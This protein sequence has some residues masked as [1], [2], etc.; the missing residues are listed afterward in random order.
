MGRWPAR[1]YS[2]TSKQ[3][4]HDPP[5]GPADR[6]RRSS[7]GLTCTKF[8]ASQARSLNPLGRT[9]ASHS[10]PALYAYKTRY[11]PARRRPGRAESCR[12]PWTDID[13]SLSLWTISASMYQSYRVH[14]RS[15]L[16]RVAD[17]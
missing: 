1:A 16:A 3:G 12:A 11:R 7:L 5:A 17:T 10:I 8:L 13:L 6:E 14:S 2:K 9:H 15:L 4:R